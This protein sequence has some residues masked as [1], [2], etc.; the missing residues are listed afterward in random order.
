MV[1]G[2]TGSLGS[3]KTTVANMCRR[4]GAK[5]ID[6][7]RIAHNL[8]RPRSRVYR[9]IVDCFGKEILSGSRRRINRKRLAEIVF[10]NSRALKKLNAI[11]HPEILKIIR[12]RINKSSEGE[13][14]IID[15]PLLIETGLERWVD[16]VVVVR[17]DPEVKIRR[18]KKCGLTTDEIKKRLD[19]QLPEDNK[20]RQA[21]FVIDNSGRR[22]Q[23]EKQIKEI[24]NKIM[25]G[26]RK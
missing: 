1:I 18:L 17:A 15:A 3:G 12:N 20:L 21:D 19:V 22:S 5:V 2:I 14:L 26:R 25:K 23:T 7:D 16:S 13:N 6:A 9:R 11:M 8:M 24:W 4:L 10:S